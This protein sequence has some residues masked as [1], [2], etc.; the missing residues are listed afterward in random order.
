MPFSLFI[1][2][3]SNVIFNVSSWSQMNRQWLGTANSKLFQEAKGSFRG[4]SVSL[5]YFFITKKDSLRGKRDCS[6]ELADLVRHVQ[7]LILLLKFFYLNMW[8]DNTLFGVLFCRMGLPL[9]RQLIFWSCDIKIP[10]TKKMLFS[11]YSQL[12]PSPKIKSR[13]WFCLYRASVSYIP[14]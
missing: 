3:K 12:S 1:I 4:H 10:T 9:Q 6:S 14:T 8:L 2:V 7:I 13:G 5:F 11:F